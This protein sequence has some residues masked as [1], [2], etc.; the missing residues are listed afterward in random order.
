MV[1]VI[2]VAAAACGR[3]AGA[4]NS[5]AGATDGGPDASTA[6]CSPTAVFG[7][8]ALVPGLNLNTS[9][10]EYNPQL[11]QDELGMY[12]VRDPGEVGGPDIY[13]TTRASIDADFSNPTVVANVN[14]A[15]TGEYHPTVTADGLTMYLSTNQAGSLNGSLDVFVATRPSTSV[16]FSKPVP[17]AA[18]NSDVPERGTYVMPDG[19]ALYFSRQSPGAEAIYRAALGATGFGA[20]VPVQGL[21]AVGA[22]G[23]P[24]VSAD[25]RTIFFV[26]NNGGTDTDI[27]AAT[28]ASATSAFSAPARIAELSTA[29]HTEE[30]GWI[31]PDGCVLYFASDRAGG[32]AFDLYFAR[33][34]R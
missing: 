23:I 21:G 16:D 4:P 22:A 31:S 9:A 34:G 25:E 1:I 3:V 28:R 32:T 7:E 13:V 27:W 5:D 8:P 2:S 19:H 17:V 11:T 15:T 29:G 20:P 26:S 33:R 6:R 18:V 12:F 14:G 10:F 30:P 24:V